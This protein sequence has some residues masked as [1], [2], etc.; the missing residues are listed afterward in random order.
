M[1]TAARAGMAAAVG[2]AAFLGA[3]TLLRENPLSVVRLAVAGAA[4]ASCSVIDVIERRI[5]NR[6]VV[7]ALAASAG[8]AATDGVRP[9]ALAGGLTVAALL[10]ALSLFRADALGMGDAKLALVV[11][12][13][14]AEHAAAAIVS[15]LAIAAVAGALFVLV[16][17]RPARSTALPLAPFLAM[18]ALLSLFLAAWAG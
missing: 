8:L 18:G 7:P 15:G 5:P 11:G 1:N 10:L 16:T 4:I 13:G 2:A 6:L 17:H 14:L 3:G 12:V 9:H